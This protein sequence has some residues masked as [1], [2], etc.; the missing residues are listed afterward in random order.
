[1]KQMDVKGNAALLAALREEMLRHRRAIESLLA[2]AAASGQPLSL[3]E[4]GRL[5]DHV[6]DIKRLASRYEQLSSS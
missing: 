6:S 4:R 3:L 2:E 5:D 1:M